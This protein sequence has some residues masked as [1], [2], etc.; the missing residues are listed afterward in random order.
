MNLHLLLFAATVALVPTIASADVLFQKDLTFSQ[1]RGT[2]P[3]VTLEDRVGYSVSFSGSDIESMQPVYLFDELIL[4]AADIGKTFTASAANDPNFASSAAVLTNGTDEQYFT[5]VRYFRVGSPSSP[6]NTS[7]AQESALLGRT[8]AAP[9][10]AGHEID[11]INLTLNSFSV[12]DTILLGEQPGRRYDLGV[13]LT[14]EGI[15]VPEPGML[16][17]VPVVGMLMRRRRA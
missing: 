14:I 4:S 7:W 6:T 11:G 8:E 2:S 16:V 13:T 3:G 5:R 12:T 17:V 1:A 10:L 15:A 9:D